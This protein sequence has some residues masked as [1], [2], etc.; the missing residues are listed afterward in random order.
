MIKSDFYFKFQFE[1]YRDYRSE[2]GLYNLKK[3]LVTVFKTLKNI[4]LTIILILHFTSQG[5]P[6]FVANYAVNH[7][8]SLD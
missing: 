8:R 1:N 6:I 5:L 2:L 4:L 3:N 7:L